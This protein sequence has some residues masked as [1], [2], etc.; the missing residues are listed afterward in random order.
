MPASRPGHRGDRIPSGAG[1]PGRAWRALA[2][3]QRMAALAAGGLFGAMFLPWYGKSVLIQNRFAKDSLTPFG[4]PSFVEAAVLLVA[5]AV[6]YLLFARGERR[7]FHL[8]GGDGAVIMA[9]GAWV[10]LLLVWRMFDKPD[11]SGAGAT[12]GLQWGIFV[13]LGFAVALS[14]A[15]SRVRAAHR[16]EPA[17]PLAPEHDARPPTGE[18][19]TN[20]RLRDDRP[21]LAETEVIA[22]RGTRHSSRPDGPHDENPASGSLPG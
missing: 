9:A 8:P 16:P 20:V 21:H 12:V 18:L 14:V 17:L 22:G 5:A 10:S 7:A 3:D 6:L 13:A 2:R 15:G 11:V 1:R 19:V 4:A